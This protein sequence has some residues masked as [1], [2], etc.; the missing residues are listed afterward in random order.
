VVLL[1]LAVFL[2]WRPFPRTPPAAALSG[3][4]AP[5]SGAVPAP[6]ASGRLSAGMIASAA[7]GVVAGLMGIGG[8]PLQ[9]VVLTHLM[10]VPVHIAMRASGRAVRGGDV[11]GRGYNLL[12]LGI[13][14]PTETPGSRR[15]R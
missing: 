8:S 5:A 7:V 3:R 12:V 10:H 6:P 11:R 14:A 1:G 9:V 2:L 4:P 15:H 13:E